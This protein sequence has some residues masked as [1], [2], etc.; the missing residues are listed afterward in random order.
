[1]GAPHTVTVISACRS[2]SFVPAVRAPDRLIITAAAADRNSFGCSDAN[3]WTWFGKAFFDEALRETRSLPDAFARAARLVTTWEAE[4][5]EVPSDPQIA[6]GAEV[7][8][9]LEAL[10]R[11]AGE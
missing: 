2:G 10:A 9:A 1:M 7:E 3:D 11:D 4:I 6:V 8:E 5:G